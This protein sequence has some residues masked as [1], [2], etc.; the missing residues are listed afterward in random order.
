[1]QRILTGMAL[2]IVALTFA[3]GEAFAAKCVRT[4]GS[5]IGI[6]REVAAFMANAAASNAAKAWG[7]DGVKITKLKESCAFETLSYNCKVTVKACK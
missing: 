3:G 2:S 5:G 6:V 1:M 7:G 4:G